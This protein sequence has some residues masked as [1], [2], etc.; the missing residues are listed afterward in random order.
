MPLPPDA[1]AVRTHDLPRTQAGTVLDYNYAWVVQECLAPPV[2][3]FG[4]VNFVVVFCGDTGQAQGTSLLVGP[5]HHFLF[6]FQQDLVWPQRKT[7]ER[8]Q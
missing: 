3:A 4:E 8:G 6:A 2:N 5:P 7:T 1:Y